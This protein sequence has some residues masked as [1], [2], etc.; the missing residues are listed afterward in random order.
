MSNE[1]IT[2][3]NLNFIDFT[4]KQTSAIEES[5]SYCMSLTH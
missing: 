2:N 5:S 1:E 3:K 4:L